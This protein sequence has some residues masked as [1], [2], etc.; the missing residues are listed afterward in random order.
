MGRINASAVS[1]QQRQ[2]TT[3]NRGRRTTG[4]DTAG[5]TLNMHTRQSKRGPGNHDREHSDTRAGSVVYRLASTH[6]SHSLYFLQNELAAEVPKVLRECS[7]VNVSVCAKRE[8]SKRLRKSRDPTRNAH[9]S[10]TGGNRTSMART[11]ALSLRPVKLHQPHLS[12]QRSSVGRHAF[13]DSGQVDRP[14]VQ[15]SSAH[16]FRCSLRH[17]KDASCRLRH[18]AQREPRRFPSSASG[19]VVG[20]N[21]HIWE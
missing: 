20:V 3:E 13:P 21:P 2:H 14:I 4:K 6:A 17:K 18:K 11:R 19:M 7:L 8:G 16:L 9:M 12:I 5:C 15:R 10:A 1:A